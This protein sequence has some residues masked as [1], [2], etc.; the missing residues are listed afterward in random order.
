[1]KVSVV[2]PVFNKAPFLQECLDSVFGQSHADMEVIAVDD[3]STDG[4]WEIL[5]SSPDPRLQ[6]VR[7]ERNGGPAAAA[8]SAMDLATG[9]YIIR[10]DADDIS[11]PERFEAQV[12]FMEDHPHLGMSGTRVIDLDRPD[13]ERIVPLGEERCM[14]EVF[15]TVPIMQP[16]AIYRRRTLIEHGLSFDPAW[17][18]IGEDWLFFVSAAQHTRMDNLDRVLVRYRTGPQNISYGQDMHRRWREALQ[19][20]LPLLGLDASEENIAFHLLTKPS[21]LA[22]PTPGLV[23][24]FAHWLETLRNEGAPAYVSPEA[25]GE[26]IDRAWNR[27]FYALCD[28]DVR[29]ALAHWRLTRPHDPGRLLYLMKVLV[30]ARLQPRSGSSIS[31]GR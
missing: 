12:R 30:A 3:C 2:I 20:G 4:S 10:V 15:F 19:V 29:S 21:F 7:L 22:R 18:R 11:L 25:F 17:P 9:E 8:R 5:R 1:M 26:R 23:R 13:Q 24:A 16:T 31:A 6:A 27:L 14:A 28:R